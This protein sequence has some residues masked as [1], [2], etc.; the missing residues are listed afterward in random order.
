[1]AGAN[2]V[3]QVVT[4]IATPLLTRI[5]G[6]S[7]IGGY[8][9]VFATVMVLAPIAT[10]RFEAAIPLVGRD[11]EVV[12]LIRL[13]LAM[14]TLVSG[15]VLIVTLALPGVLPRSEEVTS[16]EWARGLPPM[17]YATAA[18]AVMSQALVQAREYR[19]LAVRTVSS[20]AATT[21]GQV[22]VGLVAPSLSGM[23]IG[24]LFGRLVA[25]LQMRHGLTR[26]HGRVAPAKAGGLARRYARFCSQLTLAAVLNGL[27]G[28]APVLLMGLWYGASASAFVGISY[29]ILTVPAV[30]IGSAVGQVLLGESAN[31]TRAVGYVPRHLATSALRRLSPIALGV[32]VAPWLVPTSMVTALL[33]GE[34]AAVSG[35]A[36][37]LAPVAAASLLAAPLAN[38][39]TATEASALVLRIDTV[40]FFLTFGLGA[41]AFHSGLPELA[42]L[43]SMAIGLVA[44]YAAYVYFALRATHRGP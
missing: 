7:V 35:Y 19:G 15:L 5:Y 16:L 43:A 33:G 41:V 2:L 34:W 10:W 14:A 13:A 44:T 40:R 24:Q 22:G 37:I 21:V 39:L 30:M 38:V 12:G 28:N 8:A 20:A 1:M 9:I 17:L 36:K 18:F 23:V 31:S 11:S 32:A 4:L 42:T 25:I 27:S 3:A 29:R 26:L 6:P